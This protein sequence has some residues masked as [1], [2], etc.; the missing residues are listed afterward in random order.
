MMTVTGFGDGATGVD[1]AAEVAVGKAAG[2]AALQ[3]RDLWSRLVAYAE[4]VK[5]RLVVLLSLG[6]VVGGAAGFASL[7]GTAPPGVGLR[8]AWATVA[9]ALGCMGANAITGYIDRDMDAVMERTRHRPV[10]T[11]RLRPAES[12]IFGLVLVAAACLVAAVHTNRW[13]VAWLLFGVVDSAVIYNG[14]TKPRTPWNVILGSP[15]GGTPVMVGA[16]AVTGAAFSLVPFIVAALVVAWT[17]LHIW[18][19]AIRHVADYRRAGVPMLPVVVGVPKAARCVGWASL[20]LCATAALLA[21]VGGFSPCAVVLTLALQVPVVAQALAV[22]RSPT[23]ERA[24][25]LFKL[26]SPYLAAV[27][28]ITIWQSLAG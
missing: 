19:L 24:W 2:G 9:V 27:F 16:A 21:F 13:A 1:D 17:P 4:A 26:S 5:F 12:L 20:G 28:L 14:L 11:G 3:A 15:A 23:P 10:P 7:G 8:L 22:M 25:V 18:S 6:A